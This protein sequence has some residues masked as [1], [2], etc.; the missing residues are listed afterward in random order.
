MPPTC[1]D[2]TAATASARLRPR[3]SPV[4]RSAGAAGRARGRRSGRSTDVVPCRRLPVI[5]PS[6]SPSVRVAVAHADRVCSG[7]RRPAAAVHRA[8]AHGGAAG[9][10]A[11]NANATNDSGDEAQRPA[12]EVAP[13]AQPQH[14]GRHVRQEE[15]RDVAERD[16]RRPTTAR[17]GSAGAACSHTVGSVP[18]NRNLSTSIC[19]CHHVGMPSVSEMPRR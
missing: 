13:A 18:K 17:R 15:E 6:R 14:G 12:V 7:G 19:G 5:W 2:G 3:R 4:A 11:K 16:E 8:A 1:S 9:I 10:S